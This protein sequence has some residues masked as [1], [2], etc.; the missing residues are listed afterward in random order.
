MGLQGDG[1]SNFFGLM[2]AAQFDKAPLAEAIRPVK[3]EGE[4]EG[5]VPEALK[6]L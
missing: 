5:E 6:K 3:T 2:S 4:G 1:T